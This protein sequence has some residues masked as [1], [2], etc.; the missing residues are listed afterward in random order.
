M[1]FRLRFIVSL[2]VFLFS[3]SVVLA[4]TPPPGGGGVGAPIDGLSGLLILASIG[5]AGKQFSNRNNR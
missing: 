2:L 1:W 5:Y 3:A 4:Q